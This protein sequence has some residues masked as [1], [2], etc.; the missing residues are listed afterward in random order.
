MQSIEVFSDVEN[1]YSTTSTSKI[2]YNDTQQTFFVFLNNLKLIT[3]KLTSLNFPLSKDTQP[4][5]RIS[6]I[7]FPLVSKLQYSQFDYSSNTNAFIF[8]ENGFAWVERAVLPESLNS[9][10]VGFKKIGHMNI[11]EEPIRI[12]FSPLFDDAVCI[13]YQQNYFRMFDLEDSLENPAFEIKIDCQANEEKIIDFSFSKKHDGL[14]LE[15][16]VCFFISNKSKIYAFYPLT[17]RRFGP[18]TQLLE[19]QNIPKIM[20]DYFQEFKSSKMEDIDNFHQFNKN[21]KKN[22]QFLYR[23]DETTNNSLIY[24]HVS[25]FEKV[26]LVYLLVF[27]TQ[28]NY[29]INCFIAPFSVFGIKRQLLKVNDASI[30]KEFDTIQSIKSFSKGICLVKKSKILIVNLDSFKNVKFIAKKQVFQEQIT[31]IFKNCFQIINCKS[32][33]EEFLDVSVQNN[34]K[35]ITLSGIKA[36]SAIIVGITDLSFLQNCQKPTETKILES[37]KNIKASGSND[38]DNRIKEFE[39]ELREVDEI[40][41]SFDE[42]AQFSEN[43]FE[44]ISSKVIHVEKMSEKFEVEKK[45]KLEKMKNQ[46]LANQ[47]SFREIKSSITVFETNFELLKKRLETFDTNSQKL[48]ERFTVLSS[49][50]SII[51]KN[52]FVFPPDNFLEFADLEIKHQSLDFDGFCQKVF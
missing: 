15:H 8:L 5:R 44:K 10:I 37:V 14:K 13:L 39:Q 3:Y 29:R 47:G 11:K 50:N 1:I 25:F 9:S 52:E 51:I 38:F 20:I 36:K 2:V 34:S 28:T 18:V 30:S 43:D 12:K 40:I 6:S 26:G 41:S 17:P 16:F 42:K 49:L 48:N 45:E 4:S 31:S 24:F 23:V 46:K 32:N 35:V 27:E 7:Q 22:L 19:N 21:A 33:N